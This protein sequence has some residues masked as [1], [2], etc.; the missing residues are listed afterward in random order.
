MGSFVFVGPTTGLKVQ[1]W[2][3]DETLSFDHFEAVECAACQRMHLVNPRTGKVSG[4]ES[5][6]DTENR[7]NRD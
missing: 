6:A 7:A 2:A 4:S 3:S 5:G 1:S